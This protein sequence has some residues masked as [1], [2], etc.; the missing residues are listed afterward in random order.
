MLHAFFTFTIKKPPNFRLWG[1]QL[2]DFLTILEGEEDIESFFRFFSF[3]FILLNKTLF[4]ILLW[5]VHVRTHP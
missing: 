2:R 1:V 5:I 3:S 4:L